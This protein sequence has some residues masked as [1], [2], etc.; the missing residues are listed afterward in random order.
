M[1]IIKNRELQNVHNKYRTLKSKNT[2]VA[3]NAI[4][5]ALNNKL[6]VNEISEEQYS[7]FNSILKEVYKERL[8]SL[9]VEDK[10]NIFFDKINTNIEKVFF[11]L[12]E[13]DNKNRSV[14]I[15]YKKKNFKIVKYGK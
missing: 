6:K 5:E 10:F 13:P 11:D 14:S 9:L 4:I 7:I 15:V 1:E 3:Y 2:E 12:I 8:M